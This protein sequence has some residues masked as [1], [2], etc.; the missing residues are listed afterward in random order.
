MF[1]QNNY[2]GWRTYV[3]VQ[4][5]SALQ[6][7]TSVGNNPS[8]LTS[9]C[10]FG[11]T[12][13]LVVRVKKKK[14]NCQLFIFHISLSVTV[15]FTALTYELFLFLDCNIFASLNH[16]GSGTKVQEG[17]IQLLLAAK[18]RCV[19]SWCCRL[20]QRTS[21]ASELNVGWFFFCHKT[22]TPFYPQIVPFSLP[23]TA[24]LRARQQVRCLLYETIFTVY[25][26]LS[27]Q[28]VMADGLL[29]LFL[30]LLGLCSP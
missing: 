11:F 22:H 17:L 13:K 3:L 23:P 6:I 8:P 5:D 29:G 15:V 27:V 25:V 18:V 30:L 9:L 14:K 1:L 2:D 7:T 12:R 28:Q 24:L 10:G 4:Q 16:K 26:G 21:P 19:R 20:L